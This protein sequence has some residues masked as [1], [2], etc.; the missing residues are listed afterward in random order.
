M[1]SKGIDD[2]S[3]DFEERECGGRG[4]KAKS[5]DINTVKQSSARGMRLYG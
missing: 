5:H 2:L 4:S 3:T 1:G